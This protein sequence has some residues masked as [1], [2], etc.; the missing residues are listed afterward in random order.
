WPTARVATRVQAI[1][2]FAALM[3]GHREEVVRLLMWEIG[4][5]RPDAE[6][7]F[8]RTVQYI[9]DTVDAVKELDRT[10]A[11]FALEEG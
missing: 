8:D 4:K 5:T 1:E 2:R 7:E 10:S 11:R 9:V 3:R 6:S